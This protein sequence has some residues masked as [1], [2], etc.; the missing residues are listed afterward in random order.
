M[1]VMMSMMTMMITMMMMTMMTPMKTNDSD[2]NDDYDHKKCIFVL[3][4]QDLLHARSD[5][6]YEIVTITQSCSQMKWQRTSYS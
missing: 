6:E 3:T 2:V 1:M 4:S 5:K